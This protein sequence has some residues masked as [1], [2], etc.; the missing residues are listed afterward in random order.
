MIDPSHELPVCR[1]AELLEIS[2]SNVYYLR[3]PVCQADLALMRRIDE[4]Y[5]SF[6]FAGA[7]MLRDMDMLVDADPKL[8]SLGDVCRNSTDPPENPTIEAAPASQTKLPGHSKI[9]TQVKFNS[10]ATPMTSCKR[11]FALI[12][13]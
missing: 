5:L 8:T 2:R 12:A 1:Q 10:A 11:S 13:A 4:L 3:Q 6:T 7:R 9:G